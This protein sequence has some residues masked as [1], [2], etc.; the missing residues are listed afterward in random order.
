MYDSSNYWIA[1]PLHLCSLITE[2]LPRTND[3]IL[4]ASIHPNT[5]EIHNSLPKSLT[6]ARCARV[7]LADRQSC[8]NLYSQNASWLDAPPNNLHTASLNENGSCHTTGR[9]LL[10]PW[11]SGIIIWDSQKFACPDHQTM[12]AQTLFVVGK[13]DPKPQPA[14]RCSFVKPNTAISKS[15]LY[16]NGQCLNIQTHKNMSKFMI[17]CIYIYMCVNKRSACLTVSCL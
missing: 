7:P 14:L 5:S 15:L 6:R 16:L 13:Q 2:N 8:W 11:T 17:I 1:W 9:E 3:R 4:S 10:A 12:K